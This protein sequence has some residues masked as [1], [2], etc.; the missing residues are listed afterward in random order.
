MWHAA[1]QQWIIGHEA[2]D[3]SVSDVGGCSNGP[4]TVD[5]VNKVYWTC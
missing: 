1:S 2:S 3:K 5:L 4:E